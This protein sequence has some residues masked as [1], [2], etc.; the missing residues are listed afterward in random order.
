MFWSSISLSPTAIASPP[1]PLTEL[2]FPPL[3]PTPTLTPATFKLRFSSTCRCTKTD[4]TSQHEETPPNPYPEQDETPQAAAAAEEETFQVL[5]AIH[6]QYNDILIVDTP[7]S[8]MLLL[9]STHNVHSVLQKGDEKWTGSYWDEFV[10]LPPIVPEGPIAI[11]GLGGGTAAH[12]MLDVWPSLQLEGWE[13]DEILIDKAREYFGLSNLEK[14]NDV[15]GQ[16]QVHIDDAFSHEQHRP[17]GYAG[18]IIDLF[19]DG[20]VLSQLQEF[21]WQSKGELRPLILKSHPTKILLI[22]TPMED[23]EGTYYLSPATNET[24]TIIC[25]RANQKDLYFM[26]NTGQEFEVF[27]NVHWLVF[28]YHLHVSCPYLTGCNMFYNCLCQVEIWLELSD[29]LMPGGRLMVNCGGVSESSLDGKVQHPSIDDIWMQNSTIKALAEAFPGQVCCN[30]MHVKEQEYDL[31]DP[32]YDEYSEE[33]E[34]VYV[35]QPVGEQLLAINMKAEFLKAV[36]PIEL[37]MQKCKGVTLG[38]LSP[39]LFAVVDP[40]YRQ[41]INKGISLAIL[42]SGE[43]GVGKYLAYM[44]GRVNNALEQSVE[45]NVLESNP[46]LEAF[47]NTKTVD[48]LDELEEY[49]ATRGAMDVVWISQTE[50]DAVFLFVVN[51]KRMPESQGQNYL[52]LTGPLPDLTSWS[53][54][55]PSCLSEAVKQWKPCRPFH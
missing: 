27:T 5:T 28:S 31:L 6:T 37:E 52:A 14:C 53:A 40:S 42:V 32:M 33:S 13:I 38:E 50:Q 47:G 22:Q 55:V 24:G 4:L 48:A 17:S 16:L 2:F 35:R 10:S 9:D 30:T 49:L 8:R 12:L 11:Y 43:N 41:M 7:Q 21:P 18:I 15:G 46:A 39:H 20:K 26:R 19:S 1:F 54:M 51:W 45:Q 23:L 25:S 34:N 44:G 29:R 36:F 3:S